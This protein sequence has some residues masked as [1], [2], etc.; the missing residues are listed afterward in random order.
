MLYCDPE[1]LTEKQKKEKGAL[2]LPSVLTPEIMAKAVK[3]LLGELN[4]TLRQELQS[5]SK[6]QRQKEK[7]EKKE[8][9]YKIFVLKMIIYRKR[10][11]E[12]QTEGQRER[13]KMISLFF[14][15]R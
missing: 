6:S 13:K 7:K 11:S 12:R 8:K 3:I 14:F 4:E 2:E 1:N 10:K 5:G 9:N 15:E